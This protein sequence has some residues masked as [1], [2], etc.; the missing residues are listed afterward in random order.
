MYQEKEMKNKK[1]ITLIALIITIIVLL[2]LAGVS[3]SMVV[4]ENGILN[5]ATDASKKTNEAKD[6]EQRQFA[7]AEAAMNFEN[8]EYE[9]KKGEKVTIPTGFAVSQVEGENTV[10]DGLVIID[11]KGNEFVWIPVKS[12]AEYKKKIGKYNHSITNG[13]DDSFTDINQVQRGDLLGI[14]NL[15]GTKIEGWVQTQPEADVIVNAGGFYVGRYEAGIVVNE[16]INYEEKPEIVVKKNVQ[17]ARASNYQNA[18]NFANN[19]KI[20]NNVQSGLITGTE[21]DVMCSFIGYDI[22]DKDCGNWANY[23]TTE[24]SNY[25]GYYAP[26]G[27]LGWNFTNGLIKLGNSETTEEN[28]AIF[29]TGSF[30]TS[31]GKNTKQKNIYDI[32]GNV[33]EYTT[34]ISTSEELYHIIRRGGNAWSSKDEANAME[35]DG[36]VGIGWKGADWADGFRIVLYVKKN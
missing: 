25:N 21:W 19:W 28:I 10:E 23:R 22:T 27:S 15:L 14:E 1:G 32:A 17:P 20:D 2:I 7:M 34:E 13:S 30:V 35:R 6:E 8:T 31:T 3:I 4:G 5:R 33:Y 11:T 9:D 36:S 18:L 29:P 16:K 12:K 26:K 24:S